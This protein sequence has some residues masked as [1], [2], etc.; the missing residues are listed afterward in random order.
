MGSPE[1]VGNAFEHPQHTVYL[2]D[3]LIGKYEVTNKQYVEFLNAIGKNDDGAGH[4]LVDLNIAAIKS[5]NSTYR[6]MKKWEDHPVVGVSWYGAKAYA[7]WDGGRLLTEAEWEKAARGTDEREW[8]WGNVWETANCNSWEAGP[9]S[10][11]P[12]GSYPAG[13]SPYSVHDLAGNVYEWVADWYQ[14]DYYQTSPLQNPKG[15]DSGTFRIIRGG[16]WVEP[17]DKCRSAARVGQLPS[18][19][20]SDFGFRIVKDIRD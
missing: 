16:S 12:V 5:K 7:E 8:P 1:G 20:D 14:E 17:G 18:S 11:S 9:H 13:V 2:D 10:T 3:F 4:T 15:P 6:V 19:A